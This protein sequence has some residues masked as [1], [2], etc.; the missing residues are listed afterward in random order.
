[1]PGELRFLRYFVMVVSIRFENRLVFIR[2]DK[3]STHE[4]A[5]FLVAFARTVVDVITCNELN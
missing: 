1:M 5:D 3:L 2:Y 4:L